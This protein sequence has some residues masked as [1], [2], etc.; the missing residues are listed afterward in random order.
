MQILLVNAAVYSEKTQAL[1][2]QRECHHHSKLRSGKDF[3]V[4]RQS[5]EEDVRGNMPE[6]KRFIKQLLHIE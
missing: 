3:G 5:T 6:M 2:G 1:L 4:C